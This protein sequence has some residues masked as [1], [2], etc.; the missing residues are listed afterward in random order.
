MSRK[1]RRMHVKHLQPQH[2]ANVASTSS[3]YI[4]VHVLMS[5]LL[6]F[7]LNTRNLFLKKIMKWKRKVVK[8]VAGRRYAY[9]IIR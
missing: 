1:L 3:G 7:K 4:R 9:Y 2:G 5:Y 6:E 8:I